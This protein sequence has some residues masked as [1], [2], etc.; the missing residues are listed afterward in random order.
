M[1]IQELELNVLIEK[2]RSNDT[3]VG[4][5]LYLTG[6]LRRHGIMLCFVLD[7]D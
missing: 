7:N 1:R 2:I 4:S 6:I 5:E 3:S